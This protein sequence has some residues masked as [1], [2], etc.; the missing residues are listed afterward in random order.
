[1]ISLEQRL[2]SYKQQLF[3]VDVPENLREKL[4]VSDDEL[5]QKWIEKVSLFAVDFGVFF[6]Q[7]ILP[8]LQ[9]GDSLESLFGP[10]L[11]NC[12]AGKNRSVVG[13]ILLEATGVSVVNTDEKISGSH[14]CSS[15]EAETIVKHIEPNADI[16]QKGGF[17]NGVLIQTFFTFLDLPVDSNPTLISELSEAEKDNEVER[18]KKLE[19]SMLV[20]PFYIWRLL[21]KNNKDTVGLQAVI[22]NTRFSLLKKLVQENMPELK[23]YLSKEQLKSLE[24]ALTSLN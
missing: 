4:R 12:S 18:I 14:G 20:E 8:A 10:S 9:N 21:C 15:F 13:G 17:I 11:T 2:L 7:I 3:A 19:K 24:S 5:Y 1:M 23:N 22:V 6:F 16:T